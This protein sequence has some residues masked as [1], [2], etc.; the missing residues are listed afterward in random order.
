MA[1]DDEVKPASRSEARDRTLQTIR[2][3]D[4][5]MDAKKELE[6]L[7]SAKF[8][9]RNFFD[10]VNFVQTAALS[11]LWDS[12]LRNQLDSKNMERNFMILSKEGNDIVGSAGLE[13][14]TIRKLIDRFSMGI[15]GYKILGHDDDEDV[16]GVMSNVAVRKDKRGQGL[17]RELLR[18]AE[19]KANALGYIEIYIMVESSNLSAV[20]LYKSG[21][22]KRLFSTNTKVV[23]PDGFFIKAKPV[24]V[25]IMRKRLSG[26]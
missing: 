8:L 13:S 14:W 20:Q 24:E 4:L 12:E 25:D 26:E 21:G 18:A 16:V 15:E 5:N 11:G 6:V 1:M 9:A 22:Y 19:E 7:E 23:E 2:E 10:R 17:G 3:V